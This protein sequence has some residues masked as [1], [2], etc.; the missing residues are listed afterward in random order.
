MR[1][2]Q[3]IIAAALTL[4]MLLG[5]CSAF[6]LNGPDILTPP[7]AAGDRARIQELIDQST[8]GSYELLYPN[9]GAYKSA[10]VFRDMDNDGDDDAVALYAAKDG[11]AYA[12]FARRDGNEYT[13]ARQSELN[14][15]H[16]DRMN[17]ADI[18]A[19]GRPELLISCGAG[20]PLNSLSVF[21]SEGGDEAPLNVAQGYIGYL[22]GDFDDSGTD[23]IL[24]LTPA[25]GEGTA[26]AALLTY[27]D[28]AFAELSRCEI[29][30][31]VTEYPSLLFGTISNAVQGAA[32]D[33]T[34]SS[35]EH[36]TQVLYYDTDQ[37]C[38]YNPIYVFSGYQ[39]TRRTVSVYSTEADSG[40][41]EIPVCTL[42]EHSAD[43]DPAA[44]C[45]QVSWSS[46]DFG[47][48]ALTTQH[49]SI[50]CEDMGCMLALAPERI[51][52]VTAR[53]N[54]NGSLTIYAWEYR[55]DAPGRGEALL[56]VKYYDK[57]V[58]D[59]SRVIEAVL[60]ESNTGIYT[61]TIG[62]SPTYNSYTDDEVQKSFSVIN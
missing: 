47:Y 51:G 25:T 21:R 46:Y 6:S 2:H 62:S 52:T 37:R 14:S 53:Y 45:T 42:M 43:E 41:I 57:S 5:G 38:L 60:Y 28:G 40:L 9:N 33:G 24:V 10:V 4:V 39:D 15:S 18:D 12:L 48:M 16:I 55:D 7:H 35:G 13:A 17:F 49:V 20:A 50:L 61:Y 26:Y 8:G 3:G 31:N 23:D 1:R 32:V 30:P 34:L 44:V 56:T 11:T 54:G 27:A 19:D 36:T 29:D 58:Y 59:S 22:S